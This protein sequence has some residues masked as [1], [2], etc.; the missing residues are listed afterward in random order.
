[1][2]ALI[3][4]RQVKSGNSDFQKAGK[5]GNFAFQNAGKN[6]NSAFQ[7][8]GKNSNSAFQKAGKNGNSAFQKAGKSGNSF[9]NGYQQKSLFRS[10]NFFNPQALPYNSA[11]QGEFSPQAP[12]TA[13]GNKPAATAPQPQCGVNR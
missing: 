12:I 9:K 7:N 4:K 5:N 8:A 6:G 11:L 13:S 2:V 3:F 1:M 10:P